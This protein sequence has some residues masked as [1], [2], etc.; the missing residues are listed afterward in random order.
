MIAESLF[1]GL[2][3]PITPL[4]ILCSSPLPAAERR[5]VLALIATAKRAGR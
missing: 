1:G 4:A 3:L 2:G 5:R